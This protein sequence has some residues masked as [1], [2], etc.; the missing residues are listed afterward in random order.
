[1]LG[2]TILTTTF[3]ALASFVSASPPGCLLGAVNSYSEP[4]DV[5]AVCGEKDVAKTIAKFCGDDAKSAMESFADI[6]MG[7]GIKVC[8]YNVLFAGL[9]RG[10]RIR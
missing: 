8:K 1:M 7:A 2:R 5:K 4:S 6:C 3:F 9:G 10:E